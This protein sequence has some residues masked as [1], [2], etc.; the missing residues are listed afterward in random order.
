MSDKTDELSVQL[1]EAFERLE[2]D[3]NNGAEQPDAHQTNRKK[4]DPEAQK[5]RP[6]TE[7]SA[8]SGNRSAVDTGAKQSSAGTIISL[9]VGFIAIAI[10]SFSTYSV[11]QIQSLNDANSSANTSNANSTQQQL[12]QMR[13]EIVKL[14][15]TTASKIAVVSRTSSGDAEARVQLTA[16]L[17]QKIEAAASQ[18]KNTLGTSSEDWLIAEAE[19]LIRLANQKVLMEADAKGAVALLIAADEIIANAQGIVAFD[20][21][22]AIAEDVAKLKGVAALDIEGIFVTIGALVKQV[23]QLEQRRLQFS[24]LADDGNIQVEVT[25]DFLSRVEFLLQKIFRQL[26]N[27]VDY[28]N[29]GDVITPILPPE[30]EYYLRQNLTMTLRLTQLGLLRSNQQIYQD[31]L[32]DAKGWIE[33]YFDAGN[34]TTMAMVQTIEELGQVRVE[35]NMPNVGG[36]L[37]EIKRLMLSFHEASPRRASAVDESVMEAESV[38]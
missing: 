27:L 12:T 13:G 22:Q 11:L 19:Y 28:R 36:S 5:S 9:V 29:D 32:I 4:G 10:A 2:S 6:E 14:E 33:K 23:D 24:A 20:L 16:E 30:E 25:A 37:R 21:R 3:S 17:E 38:Q 35:Q 31:S 26:T 34:S 18:L 1:N 8:A 15:K 7:R